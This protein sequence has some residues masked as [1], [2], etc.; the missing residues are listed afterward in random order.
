MRIGIDFDNTIACYD[1][2]FH[3]A[4]L[5]RGLIPEN[6]GRDKNTVRDYLNDAGRADDFTELQGHVYGARMDLASPYPGFGE[7]VA[8]ARQ[9]GH[10]LFVVSHKTRHPILGASHDLHAAARGFLVARGLVGA[11][12]G[13]IDPDRVCFEETKQAK[14]ARIAALDCE[15]FIDDLP[16]IFAVPGFPDKARRI[17]FDPANQF[18]DFACPRN[19]DR[20]R[21]WAEISAELCRE[22]V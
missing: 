18:A 7:F 19:L 9:T 10:E 3:A 20:R 14:I 22:R 17:L 1:G 12:G 16:E 8:T 4:A 6:L 5:E 21:S 2:V 11:G 13:Q 15:V